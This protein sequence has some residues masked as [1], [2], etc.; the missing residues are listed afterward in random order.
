MAAAS[1]GSNERDHRMLAFKG[2]K[3]RKELTDRPTP[4]VRAARPLVETAAI[5]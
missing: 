2:E 1:E 5:K 4:E 3:R